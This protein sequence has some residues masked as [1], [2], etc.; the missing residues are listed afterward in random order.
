MQ[1]HEYSTCFIPQKL[2]VPASCT[3]LHDIEP[4]LYAVLYALVVAGLKVKVLDKLM[5]APVAA[6]EAA[7]LSA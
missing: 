6:I 2:E 7:T 3:W 4:L 1:K 5:C